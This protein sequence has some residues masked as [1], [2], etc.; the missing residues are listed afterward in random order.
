MSKVHS[1]KGS[2]KK[3]QTHAT[4][5]LNSSE[6]QLFRL[7]LHSFIPFSVIWFHLRQKFGEDRVLCTILHE[8]ESENGNPYSAYSSL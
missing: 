1:H 3:S 7:F 8:E 6:S 2:E 4:N 5:L